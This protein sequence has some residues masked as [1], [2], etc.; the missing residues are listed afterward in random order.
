VEDI[1]LSLG[2]SLMGG[3]SGAGETGGTGAATGTAEPGGAAGGTST[4]EAGGSGGAGTV[5][6]RDGARV[7]YLVINADDSFGFGEESL[8]AIPWEHVQ[9]DHTQQVVMVDVT[10]EQFE[11]APTFSPT[12]WPDM[13]GTDWDREW[14][15]FWSR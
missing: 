4:P 1:L 12:N 10:R 9:I 2:G 3:Q 7:L 11:N 13:T 14:R 6:Q 5:G 15:D 8:I